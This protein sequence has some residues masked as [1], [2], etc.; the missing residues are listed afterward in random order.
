MLDQLQRTVREQGM[1]IEDLL[2]EW[3]GRNTAEEE[4]RTRLNECEDRE[5]HLLALFEAYQEQIRNLKR[6]AE[7][8]DGEWAAQIGLMEQSLEHH[9]QM[10]GISLTGECGSTVDYDLHEV[11]EVIDTALPEQ[12]RRIADV[13]HVGYLYQGKVRTKAKV[14]VYAFGNTDRRTEHTTKEEKGDGH[15]YSHRD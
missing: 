7:G 1:S 11:I 3:S 12:D 14:A 6:F 8:R 10:C 2:E 4:L 5:R 13:Y 15:G 9:R